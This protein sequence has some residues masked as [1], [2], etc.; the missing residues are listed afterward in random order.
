[1]PIRDI[2]KVK[3]REWIS[4]DQAELKALAAKRK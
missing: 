3:I 4:C 1:M 2:P